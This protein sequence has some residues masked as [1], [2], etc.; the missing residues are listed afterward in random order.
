MFRGIAAEGQT[1]PV[2]KVEQEIERL[3][4]QAEL[5]QA[6]KEVLDKQKA[7]AEAEKP[8]DPAQ[9]QLEEQSAAAKAAKDA[10]DAQKAMYDAKKAA[11]ESQL[12]AMKAAVGE[13][14]GSGLTGGVEM[15]ADAGKLEAA[16]L[17]SQAVGEVSSKIDTAVRAVL[18][19][20]KPTI[21]LLASGDMP[22]FQNLSAYK[23]QSGIVH[24][25]LEESI[26][27]SK[28][29]EGQ[30]RALGAFVGEFG[31]A[32]DA[33]SKIMS[34]FRS[35]YT[36]GGVELKLDDVLLV[37]GVSD[38]LIAAKDANNKEQAAYQ[39]FVPGIYN[40]SAM[41]GAATA[42]V[43]ELSELSKTRQEAAGRAKW[44][45]DTAERL[46]K[47][48]NSAPEPQKK[49]LLEKA[50]RHKQMAADLTAAVAVYNT[51]FGKLSAVDDKG[52]IPLA[53]VVREQAIYDAVKNGVVLLVKIHNAGGGYYVKKNL[54][55]FFGG[56]PLYFMGGVSATYTLLQGSDG[57]VL[58][59]GVVP[60]YGGF[61][62]A[63]EL[64]EY[65]GQPPH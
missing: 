39:V 63:G 11:A 40:P 10:A 48:S 22:N 15:K 60:V 19:D 24:K 42:L 31:I 6:Q 5:L 20:P 44:H 35:E 3:K 7:L 30:T 46:T 27:K 4:K 53:S 37:N 26:K 33:V 21:V 13:V 52:A 12:A 55:T 47:E 1:A 41:D 57:H 25:A 58:A 38:R 43:N 29:L 49:E 36:V 14:P 56:M 54:W 28:E 51:W 65:L 45:E 62:K 9:K 23:V 50:L 2:G 16:L 34:Y 17:A 8:A 64:R 59:A 18:K 61:V 32:L